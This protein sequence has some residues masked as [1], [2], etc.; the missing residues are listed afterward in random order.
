MSEPQDDGMIL[1][2]DLKSLGQPQEPEKTKFYP[3]RHDCPLCT[4]EH[5]VM[6]RRY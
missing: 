1:A 3:T 6:I 2:G 4:Y 5:R